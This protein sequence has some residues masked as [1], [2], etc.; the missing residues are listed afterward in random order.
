LLLLVKTVRKKQQQLLPKL[1]F[2]LSALQTMEFQE[3]DCLSPLSAAFSELFTH[4]FN[5]T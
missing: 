1:R 4:K 3:T 5:K 2:L